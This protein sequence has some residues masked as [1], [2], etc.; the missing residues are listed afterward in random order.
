MNAHSQ[1]LLIVKPRYNFFPVGLAHVI[2]SLIS[3]GM[4]YEF[5]DLLRDNSDWEQKLADGSYYAV[6][7][8]GLT[9]DMPDLTHVCRRVN[10]IKPGTPFILGG[11]IVSD[12]PLDI[13]LERVP[14]DFGIR[15]EGESTLPFLLEALLENAPEK[16]ES[17][18]GL[19]FPG[20]GTNRL[21][22]NPLPKPINLS[23]HD[24]YPTWKDIDVVHYLN[25]GVGGFPGFKAF[26]VLTG[27]G[28]TG[29][30]TFCSPTNGS[31]RMRQIGD[32]IRELHDLNDRYDFEGFAFVNEILYPTSE[33][34]R[35][36]LKAYRDSGIGKPWVCLLRV[37]IDES[38]LRDM[39]ESGCIGI[40]YG[41]ESGSD[42]VLKTLRKRTHVSQIRQFARFVKKVGIPAFGSFMM[43]SDGEDEADL[44]KT[45][46]LLIEEDIVG[47][48][49]LLIAYPGTAIYDNALKTGKIKDERT[50]IDRL[51]FSNILGS[52]Q[53]RNVDY[54]NVSRIPDSRL[55]PAVMN[56]FRRY[57]THLYHKNQAED[58]CLDTLNAACPRC[59]T[60][61]TIPFRVNTILG[62]EQFCPRCFH[63][64]FYNMYLNERFRNH[65]DGLIRAVKNASSIVVYGTGINGCLMNFYDIFGLDYSKITSFI[66]EDEGST[67]RYFFNYDRETVDTF[68]NN[69]ADL[70]LLADTF[71][72]QNALEFLMSRGISRERVVSLVPETWLLF[73]KEICELS[74]SE[75]IHSLFEHGLNQCIPD[76]GSPHFSRLVADLASYLR[77][78]MNNGGRNGITVMPAGQFGVAMAKQ[79]TEQGMDV[80]GLLDNYKSGKTIEGYPVY[81]PEKDGAK[82]DGCVLIA[83]PSYGVQK[84]LKNQLITQAGIPENRIFLFGDMVLKRETGELCLQ[85]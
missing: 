2:T 16:A 5:V 25:A 26:P 46:D 1:K 37:D 76:P 83:T 15:G 68:Q 28:C 42:T 58:I 8:G 52:G 50:Y 11:K 14:F 30:C 48:G 9:G 55:F 39:K 38:V 13:L 18:D 73:V 12:M 33:R 82:V 71:G 19:V 24:L 72:R 17:I 27:R 44:A 65:Y 74:G 49:A 70:V 47:P 36:F 61:V 62:M 22:V 59:K 57:A 41:V 67:N 32:V 81:H 20:N 10:E 56:A 21:V 69:G 79:M 54:V 84:S 43:G 60:R 23:E 75:K 6:A 78:R 53:F 3:H 63:Q 7:T 4:D 29:K 77:Q 45:M 40:S 51:D 34:I 35:E 85:D 31:F 64:I 80:S 66:D